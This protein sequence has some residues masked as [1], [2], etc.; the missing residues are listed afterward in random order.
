M[1]ASRL[2]RT[3]LIKRFTEGNF[4]SL[5]SAF[6]IS[7]RIG[8]RGGAMLVLLGAKGTDSYDREVV[9]VGLLIGAGVALVA[10]SWTSLRA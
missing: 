7:E 9:A 10:G 1:P 5:R 3:G 2:A 6:A 4:H 8:L